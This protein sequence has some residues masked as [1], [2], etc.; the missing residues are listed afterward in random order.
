MTDEKHRVPDDR[1]G[2]PFTIGRHGTA[3][4]PR[5]NSRQLAIARLIARGL[6]N[7][8][9]AGEV[10]LRPTSVAEQIE[11]ILERLGLGSRVQLAEWTLAWDPQPGRRDARG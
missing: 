7:P 3:G 10:K 9:I 1:E 8:E 2:G 5:L 4:A 6:T 11:Q